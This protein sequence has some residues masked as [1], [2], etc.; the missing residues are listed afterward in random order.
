MNKPIA[1]NLQEQVLKNMKDI[2][3]LKSVSYVLATY[4]LKIVGNVDDAEDLPDPSTYT[5][6]YGD[7]Y[8]VGTE[9]PY[10]YYVF[11]RPNSSVPSAHWFNIGQLAIPG[12]QGPQGVQGPQGSQ[13]TRGSKWFSSA[14]NPGIVDGF[15]VGDIWINTNNY[16]VF[17]VYSGTPNYWQRIGN[18]KGSQGVQGP[19]G[20]QGIQGIQGPVGP[21]GPKGDPAGLFNIL[22]TVASAN[23][24]PLATSLNVSDAY[25]VGAS[26]PYDLYIVINGDN[27]NEWLNLGK[28][29]SG[30]IITIEAYGATTGTLNQNDYNVLLGNPYAIIQV[31]EDNGLGETYLRTDVYDD[32]YK[33]V[34]THVG[35][36]IVEASIN[37][38]HV[39][40]LAILANRT[41]TITERSIDLDPII[42]SFTILST[43]W[44][45]DNNIAPFTVK[46]N[47]TI[48]KTL[49]ANTIVELI[50]DDAISFA[51]YGFSIGAINGQVATIYA[52]EAPSA[53]VG[54]KIKVED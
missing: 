29:Y 2:E 32:D 52:L 19:Q 16:D 39:K 10:D 47:I 3:E 28:V 40:D 50:N 53:N 1:R 43:S 42:E 11:T 12:P 4:G 23:L 26:A 49:S 22:G 20:I 9:E 17:Q 54:L 21:Q 31:L 51:T 37:Q 15:I 48:S 7:A 45:T 44:F 24:L 30:A 6:S 46:A 18:I 8:A 27:S 13:G 33:M 34:Y 14:S 25:F 41:W 5:G 35:G 36:P 38:L